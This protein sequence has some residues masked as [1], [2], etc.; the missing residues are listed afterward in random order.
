MPTRCGCFRRGF[1]PMMLFPYVFLIMAIILICMGGGAKRGDSN[2]F[3]FAT[4]GL[5]IFM[6]LVFLL[7]FIKSDR[8]SRIYLRENSE[9]N[10][11]I[12]ITRNIRVVPWLDNDDNLMITLQIDSQGTQEQ[13]TE[14]PFSRSKRIARL[15]LK[16]LPQ[17]KMF[18]EEEED[19]N[20]LAGQRVDCCSICFEEFKNGELI[21]PFGACVHEF[22]S[23]CINSWLHCGKISC[24]LCRANLATFVD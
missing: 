11:T 16:A 18:K 14:S 23:N 13:S 6:L 7:L 8:L 12:E 9:E 19:A 24:P 22:H 17:A 10:N 1:W 3:Q 5:G 15:A 20:G 4:T 21:Q 2:I